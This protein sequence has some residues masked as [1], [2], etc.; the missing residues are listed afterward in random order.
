MFDDIDLDAHPAPCAF[1]ITGVPGSGKTTVATALAMRFSLAAH[2][3]DDA[4][5]SMIVSGSRPPATERDPEARRQILLRARNAAL[6]IDSFAAAGVVP[7][8]DDVVVRLSHLNYYRKMVRTRPFHLVVL[9]PDW[10][11]ALRRDRS[12]QK[13]VAEIWRHLDDV[14]RNELRG[15]GIWIDSSDLTVDE[16]VDAILLQSGAVALGRQEGPRRDESSR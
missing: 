6:L 13:Q 9:A 16:T 15:E 3:D 11:V 8:F 7:V 10:G 12:R 5:I 2:A 4:L 1:L 14:L